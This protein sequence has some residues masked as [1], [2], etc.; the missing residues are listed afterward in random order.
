L[1]WAQNAIPRSRVADKSK[2][3]VNGSDVVGSK[4]VIPIVM[5]SISLALS[6]ILCGAPINCKTIKS[7]GPNRRKINLRMYLVFLVQKPI[8]QLIVLKNRTFEVE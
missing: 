4:A 3:P 2:A 6:G 7:K 1:E 5:E 8:Q